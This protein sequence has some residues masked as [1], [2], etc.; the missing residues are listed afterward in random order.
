MAVTKQKTNK[1]KQHPLYRKVTHSHY[2][3]AQKII[4][5]N[6]KR[7]LQRE[8]VPLDEYF[9]ISPME[10]PHVSDEYLLINADSDLAPLIGGGVALLLMKD[11]QTE[12]VKIFPL[13]DLKKAETWK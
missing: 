9:Y 8:I 5:K 7:G 10:F 4:D 12:S 3:G 2:T 1:S 13:K 6:I 11:D